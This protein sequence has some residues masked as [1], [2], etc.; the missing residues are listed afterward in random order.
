MLHAIARGKNVHVL[1]VFLLTDF[2]QSHAVNL[3]VIVRAVTYE[4]FAVT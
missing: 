2:A 4:R 3:F 1:A